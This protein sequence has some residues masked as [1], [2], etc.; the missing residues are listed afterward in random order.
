MKILK[1]F[2][3]FFWLFATNAYEYEYAYALDFSHVDNE[4]VVPSELLKTTLDYFKTHQNQ[5]RNK[6]YI[7]IINFKEHNSKERFF[8]VDMD[9]GKAESYLVAHGRNS[10]PTYNGYATKF[11]N[12]N[13]S[14]MSSLGFYLTAET[15]NGEHGYSL[16]LDGLSTT[17]SNA[18]ARSIVIHA[19]NYV[20]PGDKIGRSFGCP[21]VEP[22]FHQLII[23][24][25]KAGAL[26]Y[27]AN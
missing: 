8:I 19:A 17:N 23:D 11:S 3:L 24:E 16:R 18:R 13:D 2:I 21:A 27:A 10:D 14:R 22:R 4:H 20:A 1:L 6:R 25:L 15:Y 9:S 5:I 26:I 12:N 7:G